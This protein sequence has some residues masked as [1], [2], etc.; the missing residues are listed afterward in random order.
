MTKNDS[1]GAPR[2]RTFRPDLSDYD[3]LIIA[4]VDYLDV[5]AA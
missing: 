5:H 2:R 1:G 4:L 3:F